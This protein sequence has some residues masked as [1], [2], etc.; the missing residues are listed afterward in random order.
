M[1]KELEAPKRASNWQFA[2]MSCRIQFHQ[3]VLFTV[4]QQTGQQNQTAKSVS[5]KAELWVLQF[6][7]TPIHLFLTAEIHTMQ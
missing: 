3:W 6:Q 5:K 7:S 2:V 4:G 1:A